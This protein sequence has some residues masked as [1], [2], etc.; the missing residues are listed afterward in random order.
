MKE[1]SVLQ[2]ITIDTEKLWG[3]REQIMGDIDINP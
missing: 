3:Q 1:Q 2:Q